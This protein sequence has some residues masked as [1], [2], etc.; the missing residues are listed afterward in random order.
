MLFEVL[1]GGRGGGGVSSVVEIVVLSGD[2]V[3]MLFIRL[4][5]GLFNVHSTIIVTPTITITPFIIPNTPT[6]IRLIPPQL[7]LQLFHSPL[8]PL[9]P[10]HQPLLLLHQQLL[11]ILVVDQLRVLLGHQHRGRWDGEGEG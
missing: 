10:L 3:G 5:L 4:V 7:L 9:I 11:L 8:Q 1:V 6:P 2:S